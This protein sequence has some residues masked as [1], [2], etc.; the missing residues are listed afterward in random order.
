[1]TTKQ[2]ISLGTYCA[3]LNGTYYALLNESRFLPLY[4]NKQHFIGSAQ[5]F[6]QE[7]GR[8]KPPLSHFKRI[9]EHHDRNY[10]MVSCF[11]L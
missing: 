6:T 4:D 3:L 5:V 1:M 7:Q 10:F 9:V 8:N 2:D 11:R